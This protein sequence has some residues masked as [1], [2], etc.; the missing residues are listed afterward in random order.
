MISILE[1][2]PS[3]TGIRYTSIDYQYKGKWDRNLNEIV[4]GIGAGYDLSDTFA[5]FAG[6]HQGQTF[7]DAESASAENTGDG[8]K[9]QE[10]S[11]NFEIGTRGQL[12][13]IG[14]DITYF[15]TQLDDMLF[16]KSAAAGIESS[17]NLGEGYTQGLEVVLGTDIGS[18]WVLG[19][20]ISLSATFTDT[21]FK[22]DGAFSYTGSSSG[23]EGTMNFL[24]FQKRC[25]T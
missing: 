9:S 4:A 3:L 11:L 5:L 15:N 16:L 2:Y 24:T 14:F 22:T 7:P 23:T 18:E 19:I 17:Y 6:V 13:S 10:K 25:L 1:H 12:G 20:P 21:E 8:L